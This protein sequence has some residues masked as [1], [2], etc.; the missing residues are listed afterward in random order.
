MPMNVAKYL[1]WA[2]LFLP[3]ME[4]AAFV[5]VA[6]TVGFWPAAAL[7]IVGSAAG[8]LVLRHAGGHHIAR[9]HGILGQGRLTAVQAD[10]TGGLI[11]IAGILLAIPGFIT[12]ALALLLLVVPLRDALGAAFGRG[13]AS[14]DDVVDLPPEQWHRVADGELPYR[15]ERGRKP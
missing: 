11:L 6:A 8:V 10:D 9:M 4:L 2:G 13:T 14:A 5:A 7:I 12:D 3:V 15:R 1:L